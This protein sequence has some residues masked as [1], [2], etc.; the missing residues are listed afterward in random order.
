MRPRV[1]LSREMG[2]PV[3]T[4]DGERVGRLV[5]LTVRLDSPHPVVHRIAVGSGRR[6]RHLL[7]WRAVAAFGEREVR[8]GEDARALT[9]Y[10]VGPDLPLE[11]DELLL[12]RDVIDTQVVD[13]AGLRLSRVADVLVVHR[14]DGRVEVAAVD[15]GAGSLLRR[16]GLGLLARGRA[17]VAVDWE[18]L[19]LTS[20]RGHV[21][22]LSTS[23][24]GM[25]RLDARGLAELLARLGTGDAT[26]VV[27]ALGPDRSSPALRASHPVH[28]SRLLR[29]LEPDDAQRLIA[30]SPPAAAEHFTALRHP[31]AAPRRRLLRTAGWRVHRPPA[32]PGAGDGHGDGDRE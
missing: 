13:L 7:P 16:L 6:I 26:D 20:S 9:A 10:A 28:R 2:Q 32:G 30:A 14:P 1:F 19:H 27:R 4:A 5:D 17:A 21:V 24:T 15:V 29:A 22:Q 23:S 25:R 18:D 8:L 31:S 11:H 3:V 12:A